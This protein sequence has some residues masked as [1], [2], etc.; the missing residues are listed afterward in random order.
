MLQEDASESNGT[1][2]GRCLK[3]VLLIST[4]HRARLSAEKGNGNTKNKKARVTKMVNLKKQ[5]FAKG[6]KESRYCNAPSEPESDDD[7][8]QEEEDTIADVDH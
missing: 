2:S 7:S 8:A 4:P 1:R 5:L 3:S 6:T